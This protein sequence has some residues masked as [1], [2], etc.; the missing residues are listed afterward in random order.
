[1]Q[2]GYHIISFSGLFALFVSC[3]ILNIIPTARLGA[4]DN[5]PINFMININR[6]LSLFLFL[7][8]FRRKVTV[9]AVIMQILNYLMIL[10]AIIVHKLL[11]INSP[12][13]DK[14][15]VILT[16]SYMGFFTVVIMID[17]IIY[18]IRNK[19]IRRNV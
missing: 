11:Y 1:M 2:Y 9:W 13:I 14:L 10:I 8:I 18:D 7:H 17:G 19:K 15:F 3:F 4:P 16:V 12:Y 6:F 5:P